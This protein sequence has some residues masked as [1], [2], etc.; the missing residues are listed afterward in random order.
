MVM[1]LLQCGHWRSVNVSKFK[2]IK[3]LIINTHTNILQETELAYS[4]WR[5]C[6][7]HQLDTGTPVDIIAASVNKFKCMAIAVADIVANESIRY[8]V[9]EEEPHFA[10]EFLSVLETLDV[11]LDIKDVVLRA[12]LTGCI[13]PSATCVNYCVLERD[14]QI[15][16]VAFEL[17]N[18]PAEV[19]SAFDDASFNVM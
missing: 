15:K 14:V 2:A 12:R 5:Q 17:K 9:D 11:L 16:S 7:T 10:T 1:I 4:N 6:E 8:L 3:F 13:L 18:L 19:K